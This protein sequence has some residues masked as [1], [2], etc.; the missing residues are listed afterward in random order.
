M[1]SHIAMIIMKLLFQHFIK[2]FYFLYGS[3]SE[4][5]VLAGTRRIRKYGFRLPDNFWKVNFRE[6]LFQ[7]TRL[8]LFDFL[9]MY[10]KIYKHK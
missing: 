1:Y 6:K 9:L 4:Q 10:M 2:F 8:V 3:N 5:H 7:T